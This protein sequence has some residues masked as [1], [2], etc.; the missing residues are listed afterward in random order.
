MPVSKKTCSKGMEGGGGE[1]PQQRSHEC[2]RRRCWLLGGRD[3]RTFNWIKMDREGPVKY[4]SIV[5]SK[6]N[7]NRIYRYFT[8]EGQ[9]FID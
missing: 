4:E 2:I 8:A 5:L 3:R 6:K 1:L 9:H 7:L